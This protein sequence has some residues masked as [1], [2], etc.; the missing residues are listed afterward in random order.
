MPAWRFLTNHAVVLLHLA[1]HPN[2]TLRD[3]STAVGLTERAVINIIRSLEEDGIASH[4]KNGRRNI[5]QID[6]AAV[7]KHLREQ[8]EPFTLE[9]IALQTAFLAKRLG[10]DASDK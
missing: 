10:G 5:Y 4:E 7:I 9:E 3:I 2:S 8:T 6:Q 1:I